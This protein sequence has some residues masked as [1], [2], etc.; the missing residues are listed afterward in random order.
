MTMKIALAA[1]VQLVSAELVI[2]GPERLINKFPN[3][4]GDGP[5]GV[6]KA[7]YANFGLIPYGHNMV[8]SHDA[9]TRF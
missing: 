5:S 7:S 3:L 4:D 9:L 8:S 6:I 2:Q 1:V